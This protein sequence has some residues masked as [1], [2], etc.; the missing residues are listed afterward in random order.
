MIRQRVSLAVAGAVVA[1]TALTAGMATSASAA[2]TIYDPTFTPGVTDLSG[3]GSDTSEIALDYVSKGHNGIEGF[4]AGKTSGR[5]ASFAAAGD[6]ASILLKSGASA[7]TRPNGSGAGKT[8]LRPATSN[9]NVDFA[10]SSSTLSAAE[11]TDGLQQSPFAVDG[12]KIAASS[13]ATNAPTVIS[14]ADLVKIYQGTITTWGQ[15]AGYNGPAPA[16][17]IKPLIPQSG[18]GTRSF[19]EA[20]LKAR[21]TGV[22]VVYGSAVGETQEHSDADIKNNPNAIA[23]FSTGRAK[24][25]PSVKLLG[26]FTAQR[27]LYNVVRQADL[28]GS[29]QTLLRSAFGTTGFLCSPEAK[30]LIEAAGFEQ[31]APTTGGGVCGAF[32]QADVTNFT[33]TNSVAKATTTALAAK[34]QNGKSVKLTAAVNSTGGLPAGKVVFLENGETVGTATVIS[35][36]ATLSLTGVPLGAHSYTATFNPTSAAAYSPSSSTA[37][38]ATVL[39]TSAI[40]VAAVS[41]AYGVA[42]KLAVNVTSDGAAAAGSVTVRGGGVS[43]TATLSNG[44]AS[45]ALPATIAAGN[46]T[47]SVTYNGDS[48]TSSSTASSSLRVAKAKSAT[49]LKLS[50]SKIKASQKGKATVTVKLSGASV[51]ATGKV[52]L[53]AGSKTVGT[54]TVKNGKVTVTLK[55]L[56]AGTYKIKAAFAGSSNISASTSKTTTLKVTK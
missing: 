28:S 27:A 13:A 7:V 54:G 55:K 40:K 14:D 4:N 43:A 45:V 39:K 19:F 21:N 33:T 3:V 41:K 2:T 25:A 8:L 34:A 6:P 51:K 12:L 38:S 10:R 15:V 16:A 50:K 49:T 31:L 11:I 36:T 44:G 48:A 26:G 46:Q 56:K 1:T 30:P 23:P 18:S 47:L 22:S 52:T 20:Q 24:T 37:V 35:G 9:V 17:V 29:K 5:I 53:K 32:V 42:S